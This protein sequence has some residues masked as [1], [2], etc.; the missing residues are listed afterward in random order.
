MGR[1]ISVTN[2]DSAA[3]AGSVPRARSGTPIVV[4]MLLLI[5]GILWTFDLIVSAFGPPEPG[6]QVSV[7]ND[8]A[9]A[10]RVLVCS[11]PV[12][13]WTQLFGRSARAPAV[14]PG[15]EARVQLLEGSGETWTLAL[16]W[17]DLDAP[18]PVLL[19]LAADAERQIFL[20][21][22]PQGEVTYREGPAIVSNSRQHALTEQAIEALP[23][24]RSHSL[25]PELPGFAGSAPSAPD[26]WS[27]GPEPEESAEEP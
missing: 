17:L 22:G 14:A 24:L 3:P 23:E 15:S 7:R 10:L 20:R 4:G 25:L 11:D 19:D 21:A 8:H 2:P 26:A 9:V 18:P 16:Q 1:W 27:F 6:M 5:V 12:D 13:G